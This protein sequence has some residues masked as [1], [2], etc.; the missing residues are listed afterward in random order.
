[1]F[2]TILTKQKEINLDSYPYTEQGASYDIPYT[3][4]SIYLDASEPV[5][6]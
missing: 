4:G 6:Q 5:P 1:M 2:A 3:D